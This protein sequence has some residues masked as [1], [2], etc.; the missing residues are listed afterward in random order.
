M[1]SSV[2]ILI[3]THNRADL[4]ARA[5]HSLGRIHLPENIPVELLIIANAC[6]DNTKAV[7]DDIAPTL[8]FSTRCIEEPE[9]G[10]N[11]ARNRGL[12]EATGN[13]LA[14]L[15]DD[16]SVDATWLLGLLD[17]F[18]HYPADIVAGKVTL[19]WSDTPRPDWLD[20]RSAHLLSCVDH[21]AR[22]IELRKPGLAVGA[23]FAFHRHVTDSIGLFSKGLDRNR[24][25][26]LGGGD[27][28]FLTR[29]LRA[30]H[31][32][33]YAPCASLHHHVS[34]HRAT[35][36]YLC[37]ASY[38]NGLSRVFFQK[39]FPATSVLWIFFQQSYRA[40]IYT[41][42]AYLS[43]LLF[44]RKAAIHHHIRRWYSLG[45]LLGTARRLRGR[46]AA[47]IAPAPLDLR[48]PFI[49]PETSLAATVRDI[50]S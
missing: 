44:L 42:L 19:S 24:G 33:F 49:A 20:D 2:S 28:D 39:H 38:G 8:P 7:V 14:F 16:V 10:L 45:M 37:A 48:P 6:T 46:T 27:T 31:R 18:Q 21:G 43:T 47:G 25:L 15:D 50:A 30:K 34:P 23:N 35:R 32:M 3:P 41:F 4:L 36:N 1:A 26:I 22:P 12:R 29:A 11:H 40:F 17:V 13:I 5:L 9:P